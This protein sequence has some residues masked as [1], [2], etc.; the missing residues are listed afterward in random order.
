MAI[1]PFTF[2]PV[3]IDD[4][5]KFGY[6]HYREDENW[7]PPL[8]KTIYNQFCPNFSFYTRKGNKHKHFLATIGNKIVGRISA[9]INQDLKDGD[10]IS[11]GNIGFYEC[12]NDRSIS[13]DLL[14]SA[15]QWIFK[16]QNIRHVWGPMNFDIWHGYRFMTR[17]FDQD[18][19]IGEP[20]NKPFY[21]DQF[22][23]IGFRPKQNWHSLELQGRD[24][25]EEMIKPYSECYYQLK[26][27]GYRFDFFNLKSFN[28]ELHKL[29]SILSQSFSG[30][31]GY[32]QIS[33]QQFKQIFAPNRYALHPPLFTF[34]YDESNTLA[35]F[36]SAFL[37]LA[38]SI[39]QM[40]GNDNLIAKMKFLYS[41]RRVDRILF[42]MGGITPHEADKRSGLGKA[43][44]YHL[45][46]QI[47]S[48]GYKKVIVALMANSSRARNLL[49]GRENLA[50]RQY[51]LYEL[52]NV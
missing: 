38:N 4:F 16:K 37:D 3:Y 7:I 35:G 27:N 19:F 49:S 34:V 26:K 22:L 17:G 50:Q 32:T 11:I 51:T 18:I 45:I 8:K 10:G 44:F 42:Y 6:Q 29:Y 21:E 24:V 1:I 30:F 25:L 43:G 13:E 14:A 31:L 48:E 2:D 33:Y 36:A 47:L 46:T 12:L 23:H 40:K 15:T 52:R 28:S 9:F 41:R 39:R 5:I 20:Y